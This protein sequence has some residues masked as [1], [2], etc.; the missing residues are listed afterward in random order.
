MSVF[1][2]GGV[3]NITISLFPSLSF[4][5]SALEVLSPKQTAELV[6]LPL[7]GLPGKDV[8]INTVF[9]SKSPKERRLPEFLY[10][11][12]RLSVVVMTPNIISKH[13]VKLF[14]LTEKKHCS[15]ASIC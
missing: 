7:P 2:V 10:H 6:V 11:L 1:D 4:Q 8:I 3:L 5:L 13:L 15:L 12:S 9:D 14:E